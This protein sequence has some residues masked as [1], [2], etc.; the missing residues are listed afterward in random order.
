MKSFAQVINDDRITEIIICDDASDGDYCEQLHEATKNTP[1]VRLYRNDVNIGMAA[2]KVKSVELAE[3]DWCIVF[4]S[5]NILTPD[6][7]DAFEQNAG[8][9]AEN[10]FYMPDFAMPNFDY[11]EFAGK[12]FDKG[13][14][15]PYI[16]RGT[17]GA[18][19]NTSNFIVNKDAY[20]DAYKPNKDMRG[21]DTIWHIFN[22]IKNGGLLRV[23]P[24]MRYEHLVH[25]QSEYMKHMQYNLMKASEIEHLILAL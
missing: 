23:V 6:Y 24:G 19:L 22:H 5:D 14:I 18:M 4:D 9:L 10:I 20:I 8:V 3:N 11:T 21:T 7:I 25:F 2:N 13:S 1:K 12:L 17:F 15:K 16:G